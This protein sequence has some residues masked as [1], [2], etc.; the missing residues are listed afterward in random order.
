MLEGLDG[1]EWTQGQR[2]AEAVF[3]TRPLELMLPD[4]DYRRLRV[5]TAMGGD[6]KEGEL[7]LILPAAPIVERGVDVGDLAVR[8]A[9]SWSE[10]IRDQVME[11]TVA[12]NAV[13]TRTTLPL[14]AASALKVGDLL[15]FEAE[16]LERVAIEGLDEGAVALGRL[17]MVNGNRAV[18]VSILG[19]SLPKEEEDLTAQPEPEGAPPESEALMIGDTDG[20]EGP[21]PSVMPTTVADLP[22]LGNL[23]GASDAAGDLPDLSD[24]PELGDLPDLGELPPMGDLPDLGELPKMDELPDLGELPAMDDLPDLSDLPELGDLPDLSDLPDLES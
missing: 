19:D 17:G 22:D 18:R 11:S 12:I 6:A 5:S 10:T 14:A 4:L 15:H 1:E 23:S 20:P 3:D 13:L 16:A 24:L 8:A 21:E 2:V 9:T 7:V